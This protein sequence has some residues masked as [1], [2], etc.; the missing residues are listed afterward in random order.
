MKL[1]I[2]ALCLVACGAAAPTPMQQANEAHFDGDQ[3][4]CH[5]NSATRAAE[6]KCRDAVKEVYCGD[7]GALA[8]VPPACADVRLSDGGAP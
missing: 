4:M 8:A 7:G 5:L 2:A 6:D 3:A 1:A